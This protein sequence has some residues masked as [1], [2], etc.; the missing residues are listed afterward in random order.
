[1]RICAS[2]R[3]FLHLPCIEAGIFHWYFRKSMAY[4]KLMLMHLPGDGTVTGK[5]TRMW[6]FICRE[7]VWI[8]LIMRIIPL[9]FVKMLSNSAYEIDL[10]TIGTYHELAAFKFVQNHVV[11]FSFRWDLRTL[12]VFRKLHDGWGH[13]NVLLALNLCLG[14][15]NFGYDG[16]SARFFCSGLD[17]S[18]CLDLGTSCRW[19]SSGL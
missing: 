7:D 10:L 2:I 4:R 12:L 15:E 14:L 3:F 19:S 5:I 8:L 18:H 11:H 9:S 6:S 13:L 1:M 16:E 17:G